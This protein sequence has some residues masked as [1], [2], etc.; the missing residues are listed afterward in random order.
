MSPLA[1][2]LGYTFLFVLLGSANPLSAAFLTVTSSTCRYDQPCDFAPGQQANAAGV[3]IGSS[4]SRNYSFPSSPGYNF[5]YS[6]G[7]SARSE[8]NGPGNLRAYASVGGFALIPAPESNLAVTFSASSGIRIE[9]E[10]TMPYSGSFRYEWEVTGTGFVSYS[11]P[12]TPEQA[13]AGAA[14]GFT[15][16][17]VGAFGAGFAVRP[18]RTPNAPEPPPGSNFVSVT[19]NLTNQAFAETVIFNAPFLANSKTTVVLAF[20]TSAGMG[21]LFGTPTGTLNGLATADFFNTAKLKSFAVLD[22][23]GNVISNPTLNPSSGFD[24]FN[25]GV[26]DPPNTGVPEPSYFWLLGCGLAGIA[27]R[28]RAR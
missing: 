21:F 18:C 12:G 4:L 27:L 5:G 14:I 11:A 1:T 10:F 22:A 2:K 16:Q 17:A 7:A 20:S 24:Y 9:D 28:R 3:T 26:N 23:N 8:T 6:V 19:R 15:C 13:S 25:L